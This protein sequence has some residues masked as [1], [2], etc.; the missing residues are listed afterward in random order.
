MFI[1]KFSLTGNPHTFKRIA[2]EFCFICRGPAIIMTHT[3]R[4]W[5][6]LGDCTSAIYCI[7]STTTWLPSFFPQYSDLVHY[8]FQFTPLLYMK[9]LETYSNRL[10]PSNYIAPWLAWFIGCIQQCEITTLYTLKRI[11]DIDIQWVQLKNLFAVNSMTND[12]Y[13]S[14]CVWLFR[15]TYTCI[16]SLIIDV[17]HWE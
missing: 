11:N 4:L 14:M 13:I 8:F 1:P 9:T 3:W 12:C 16:I 6:C 15:C 5:A 10:Y 7:T 17:H 2:A